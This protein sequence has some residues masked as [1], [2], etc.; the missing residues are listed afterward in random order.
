MSNKIAKTRN[1][2]RTRELQATS[3]IRLAARHV[4]L[5]E[6]VEWDDIVAMLAGG[7]TQ[8]ETARAFGL[9]RSA[10]S[11]YLAN[12]TGDRRAQLDAARRASAGACMD[13]AVDSLDDASV[14]ITVP[15]SVQRGIALSRHYEKRAALA[16]RAGYAERPPPETAVVNVTPPSFTICIMGQDAGQHLIVEHKSDDDNDLV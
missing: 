3:L 10:L 16:D 15:G 13:R 4:A 14:D 1:N 2:D 12:Q 8:T 6:A 7:A 5:I 11:G 9:D